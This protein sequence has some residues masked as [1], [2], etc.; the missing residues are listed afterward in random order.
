[1][2]ANPP[3]RLY[4]TKFIR[5]N[6]L[7]P[8]LLLVLFLVTTAP[9]IA[10]EDGNSPLP[11]KVIQAVK[12]GDA[13]AIDPFMNNKVE[14]VLPGKSGVFSREQA[15]FILKDFFKE[16]Q[17]QSFEM[18]HHGTRQ[19]ATFAIG[20]Y[21]CSNGTY[22]MYFLVKNS[23]DTSVIHQIRIEKQDE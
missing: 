7:K 18:L 22:R 19:N 10:Q 20:R 13:S 17:V 23:D 1:N 4:Q 2:T 21:S 11:Q 12:Q 15:H 6:I 8:L 5:M 16:N 14:L 9:L 3:I